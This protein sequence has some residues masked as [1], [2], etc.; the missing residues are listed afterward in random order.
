MKA[1]GFRVCVS[2]FRACMIIKV[3]M[4]SL[5]VVHVDDFLCSG[6]PGDS[7]WFRGELENSFQLESLVVGPGSSAIYLGRKISW[8]EDGI[9]MEVENKYIQKMLKEWR[10]KRCTS[11]RIHGY[12]ENKQQGGNEALYD[13]HAM[14]N[15]MAHVRP[16]LS[17]A[18]TEVFRDMAKPTQQDVVKLKRIIRYLRNAKRRHKYKWQSP[19][20]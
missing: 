11:L 3:A 17:F 14:L 16:D 20:N 15:Y 9:S 18:S 1:L 7:A 13:E 8:D 5:C 10:L 4:C 6:E 2:L 19:P 12:D